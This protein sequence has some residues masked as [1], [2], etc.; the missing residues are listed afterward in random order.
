M[1]DSTD[2]SDGE[3]DPPSANLRDRKRVLPTSTGN[4]KNPSKKKQAGSK[5]AQKIRQERQ[6]AKKLRAMQ[7]ENEQLKKKL[8]KTQISPSEDDF[9]SDE[10][11][12]SD[13]DSH[14]A[15]ARI[16]KCV[17]DK[18]TMKNVEDV[19]GQRLWRVAKIVDNDKE[20]MEAT[21]QVA[22]LLKVKDENLVS[23]C[24]IYSNHVVT[25]I[26]N[27]R[28]A[29][30][31]K[32]TDVMKKYYQDNLGILPEP[33]DILKCAT[34]Q[35]DSDRMKEVFK[36]YWDHL[37]GGCLG[38]NTYEWSPKVK[39]YTTISK[40]KW[41]FDDSK[42]TFPPNTEAFLCVIYESCYDKWLHWFKKGVEAEAK[43]EEFKFDRTDVNLKNKYILQDNGQKTYSGWTAEGKLRFNEVK[44]Q[45]KQARDNAEEGKKAFFT[46]KLEKKFKDDAA[47]KG[48]VANTSGNDS[49]DTLGPQPPYPSFYQAE[50]DCLEALRN[51]HGIK[52]AT[53]ELQL[54]HNRKL[55]K[56]A[57]APVPVEQPAEPIVETCDFDE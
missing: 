3:L 9:S 45:I 7:V 17:I 50:K 25:C 35:I 52:C 15:S 10:S 22:K 19:V 46:W 53:H 43:G 42:S 55:K 38:T 54:K 27:K 8:A 36:F 40:A 39:Y 2:T 24:A 20:K 13:D 4:T 26:N 47:K 48:E 37:I 33:E 57:N 12:D 29:V 41:V 18:A 49:D 44:A 16:I 6:N 23:F 1:A 28:S 31:S 14:K 32:L 21:K 34:R 56:E 5:A 51:D 30:Q 11:E